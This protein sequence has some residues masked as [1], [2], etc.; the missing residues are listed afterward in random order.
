MSGSRYC[1]YSAINT[2][3]KIETRTAPLSSKYCAPFVSI[4]QPS[5]ETSPV[6]P[7][8]PTPEALRLDVVQQ[9]LSYIMTPSK[10]SC[11]ES[12]SDVAYPSCAAPAGIENNTC[13]MDLLNY[14]QS[15]ANRIGLECLRND[16]TAARLVDKKLNEAMS[17]GVTHQF[18]PVDFI[19]IL[20][21]SSGKST[22][23]FFRFR[24]YH[25]KSVSFFYSGCYRG[26]SLEKTLPSSQIGVVGSH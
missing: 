2:D 1:N 14:I 21:I 24:D 4:V 18:T 8:E 3:G 17:E 13:L 23:P 9:A 15:K 12:L 11:P 5:T 10:V 26:C 16:P 19:V 7:T 22:F 20:L 25:C 6:P